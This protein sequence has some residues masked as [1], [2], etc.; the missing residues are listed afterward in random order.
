MIGKVAIR[1]AL[2]SILVL[3]TAQMTNAY[4]NDYGQDV[5]TT[6]DPSPRD[7]VTGSSVNQFGAHQTNSQIDNYT[8]QDE[9]IN[10][11]RLS[12]TV[13]VLRT[14]QKSLVNRYVTALVPLKRVDP[15]ELR[16][17]ARTICRKE[18]GDA[19][20][21]QD[22]VSKQNYLV[23]VCPDFQ[24]PYVMQTLQGI[25]QQWVKE[26]S[27]GSWYT[28]YKGQNR[29]V[30][31]MMNILQFYRSPDA[32]FDFDD[33]NNAMVFFDQ[34]NVEPLF[35]W[36][37]QTVD[38][39]PSQLLMD[40]AIYEVDAS[41]NL[42]LGLDFENWKNGPGRDL[43]ELIAWNFNGGNPG[44]LFPGSPGEIADWGHL[45][46]YDVLLTT[47][48]LDFMQTKGKARLVNKAI[49]S[50]KSGT[51]G[52]LAA[53]DQVASFQSVAYTSP[54]DFTPIRVVDILD[55]YNEI[56][57]TAYSSA[58]VAAMKPAEAIDTI[59]GI[60]KNVVEVDS[61]ARAE[62]VK[63]LKEKGADGQLSVA[64][65]QSVFVSSGITLKVFHDRTLRY[66]KSG[67]V[68]ILLSI[69]PYVA[70]E[71]AEVSLALDI[72]AVNGFSPCG[73]P[74]I[75]HRYVSSD[76]EV[77]DGQPLVLAGFK[78]TA[79]V[80][81]AN[82]IP[83]LRD[84]PWV[85]YLFGHETTTKVEKQMVVILT[86]RFKLCTTNEAAPPKEFQTAVA[87]AGGKEEIPVPSSSFGFDQWLLDP[88]K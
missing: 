27:D 16:G 82:G 56:G 73:A 22:K 62:V 67:Q 79:D 80:H 40:V 70:L 39:P 43:F 50:A 8:Y 38:I 12:G 47:A 45:R 48:F 51:V 13:K 59:D 20:V 28:Y 35:R 74:I 58:D 55:Y 18:G 25:D 87:L 72:S 5:Q 46:S 49:I 60:L 65:M 37:T 75:E 29:D 85:G 81:S 19:D 76:F 33:A 24:L 84:I 54:S 34:P 7:A 71:S 9:Q 77:K 41:N 21:L 53:L 88:E 69:L 36:G 52:E 4:T 86:P 83:F 57:L 11:D 14:N 44:A 23:V 3:L 78:R 6:S 26:F 30:R 2:M 68:G 63:D 17:I 64:D 1:L 31:N 15:R 42:A 32:S 61:A 10:L 66:L